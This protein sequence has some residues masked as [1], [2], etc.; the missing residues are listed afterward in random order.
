MERRDAASNPL[1]I[2]SLEKGIEVL[3]AFGTTRPSMSLS[4][5]ADAT[6]I[7]K[8]SAQRVVFTLE[9]MGL[10]RKDPRT[11]RYTLAPKVMT[12]GYGYLVSN[13]L[14]D[15]ASPFLSALSNQTGE[16]TTM[17]EPDGIEMVYIARFVCTKFIPINLPVGSRVPMYCSGGGKAYLGALKEEEAHRLLAASTLTQR[18]AHTLTDIGAIETRLAEGRARGYQYNREEMFLGDM[19]LAAPVVDANQRPIAAIHV[20]APTSRWTLQDAEQKL[21]PAL[22]DCAMGISNAVRALGALR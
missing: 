19:T 22:I 13:P 20:T 16:T 1:F 11:R 8:S 9:A 4:E 3:Q 2:G 10:I 18:T 21:A 7:S 5:V 17:S 15:L 14:I 12:L 6:D